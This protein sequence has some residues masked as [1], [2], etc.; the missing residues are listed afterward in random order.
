MENKHQASNTGGDE[1]LH[2]IF[3]ISSEEKDEF[4]NMDLPNKMFH[5][6]LLEGELGRWAVTVR[7]QEGGVK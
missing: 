5:Q 2:W 4:T 6:V 1:P 7:W 3:R